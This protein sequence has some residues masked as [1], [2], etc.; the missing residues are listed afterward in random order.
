MIR[1]LLSATFFLLAVKLYLL[2]KQTDDLWFYLA[3]S[4]FALAA[5]SGFVRILSTYRGAKRQ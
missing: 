2:G 5:I 1:Y 4:A 3:S